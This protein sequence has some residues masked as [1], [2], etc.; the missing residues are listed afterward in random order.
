MVNTKC[1]STCLYYLINL[2]NTWEVY[3][4]EMKIYKLDIERRIEP[5]KNGT[6]TALIRRRNVS[7][8]S[9]GTQCSFGAGAFVWQRNVG[10]AEELAMISSEA[11]LSQF[12]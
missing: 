2:L 12:N 1:R 10:I 4:I 5:L 9:G 11:M 6:R 3:Y 7:C 8:T